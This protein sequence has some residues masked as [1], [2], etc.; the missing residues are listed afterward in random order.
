M[1]KLVY[2]MNVSLDGFVETPEHS[3]DWATVDE[4]IHSWWKDRIGEA[5]AFLYGRRLWEVMSVWET[6]EE[7]A[8]STPVMREF[9]RIWK[10]TPKIVF[11]TSLTSVGPNA[12]LVQGDV[13]DVLAQ[14]RQEFSGDFDVGGPTLAAQF[15]ER[16][17][18]DE[19]RPVIHPVV[20]GNGTPFFPN[21]VAPIGLRRTGTRMFASGTTYVGYAVDR[22]KEP[23]A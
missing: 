9:A 13:R 14:L 2:S 19:Y 16:G 6:L 22:T 20:L 12:R 4:E 17:L 3:L 18:I 10:A 15:I 8:A 7:D 1:G 23:T 5:D 11:S 21:L